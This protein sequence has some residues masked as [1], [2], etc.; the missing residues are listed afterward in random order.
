M[1]Y[2]PG[3]SIFAIL[4]KLFKR[5]GS[6]SFNGHAE[7]IV[8]TKGASNPVLCFNK[9]IDLVCRIGLGDNDKDLSEHDCELL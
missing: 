8:F 9:L 4:S 2:L 7:G 5:S 3:L 6:G 1:I